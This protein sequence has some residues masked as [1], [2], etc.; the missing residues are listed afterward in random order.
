M[1]GI[2]TPKKLVRVKKL[3]YWKQPRSPGIKKQGVEGIV[4]YVHW[5]LAAL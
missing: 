5:F 4:L 1:K 2:L 3:M